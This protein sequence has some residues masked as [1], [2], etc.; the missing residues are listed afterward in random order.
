MST[1]T[2]LQ[3][4]LLRFAD[5]LDRVLGWLEKPYL[6]ASAICLVAALGLNIFNLTLRNL[7]GVGVSAVYSW[8]MVLFT[9]LVFLAVF[10]VYL[11][12]M[13]VTVDLIFNRVPVPLQIVMRVSADLL[14]IACFGVIIAQLP[15][16]LEDQVG[17]IEFVGFQ[18]YTLSLPL[19]GACI[20]VVALFF[21]DILR[22]LAGEAVPGWKDG[23]VPLG[24]D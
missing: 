8:T 2:G 20:P 16:I 1:Q 9:W 5:G 22:A 10:P 13:D 17:A 14:A 21:S 11:R 15:Q 7:T 12:R 6:Y 18:R 4:R 19:I 3:L 23:E 24:A